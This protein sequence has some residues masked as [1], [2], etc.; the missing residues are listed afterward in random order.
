MF[1]PRNNIFTLFCMLGAWNYVF[2]LV[3]IFCKDYLNMSFCG[4]QIGN[5]VPILLVENVLLTFQMDKMERFRII[6]SKTTGFYTQ[7]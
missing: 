5:I 1:W 4:N 2:T 6:L 7:K 3:S